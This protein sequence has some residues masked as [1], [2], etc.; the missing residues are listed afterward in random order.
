MIRRFALLMFTALLLAACSNPADIKTPVP[1]GTTEYR[2][3]S[4]AQADAIIADWQQVA[5]AEM[6]A[7][8]VKPETKEESVFVTAQS[9]TELEAYYDASL[10]EGGWVALNRMPGNTGDVLLS[11]YDHGTVALVI[12]ALDAAKFGGTGTIVYT[13]RGHK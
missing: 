4:A 7:D 8:G 12:G 13:L 6:A 3:G 2:T 5:W 10:R 9:L 1:P 11:G